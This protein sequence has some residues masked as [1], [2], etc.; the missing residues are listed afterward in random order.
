MEGGFSD[1]VFLRKHDQGL[2]AESSSETKKLPPV[3]FYALESDQKILDILKPSTIIAYHPDIAFV[4]EVEIYKAENPLRNVK[5]YFLFYE[6]S[7]EVQKFEASVRR[8]N[9]AFESLIRQKSLMMIPVDQVS[10]FLL[11]VIRCITSTVNLP[12]MSV[13]KKYDFAMSLIFF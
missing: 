3:V 2:D 5:V 11:V 8:E 10:S 1:E 6:D 4:R 7:T 13:L 9:G 12:L